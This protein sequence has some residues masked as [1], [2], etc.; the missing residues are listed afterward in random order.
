MK[1]KN[2]SQILD[3]IKLKFDKDEIANFGLYFRGQSDF[4][5][6]LIP[7]IFRQGK[8][9]GKI[10]Y[11]EMGMYREFL[12]LRESQNKGELN[13][14]EW[15][16]LMQHY[17]LPTRLLDWTSNLLIALFFAI[18]NKEVDGALFV[19]DPISLNE[20]SDFAAGQS[21]FDFQNTQVIIRANLSKANNLKDFLQLPE[22]RK[23]VKDRELNLKIVENTV[24]NLSE[25]NDTWW[26]RTIQ[27]PIAVFPAQQNDRL[28]LQQG[29]FTIHGGKIV[30]GVPIIDSILIEDIAKDSL[31]KINIPSDEKYNIEEELKYC[32][33]NEATIFPELEYQT[34]Q[35]KNNWSK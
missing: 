15:L 31:L 34:K 24:N 23:I 26:Q 20:K 8:S 11:N 33:I 7:N 4:S 6:K 18:K 5:H 35:I 14:F 1:I 13:S 9:F 30:D 16:T 32:G 25:L 19:L 3:Y 27:T 21:M 10:K 22:I 29:K 12:L 2:I 17:G 28:F